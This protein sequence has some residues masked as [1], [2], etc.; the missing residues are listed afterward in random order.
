MSLERVPAPAPTAILALVVF[1]PFPL[2]QCIE[3][4]RSYQLVW[5]FP[6]L[7]PGCRRLRGAGAATGGWS[8]PLYR[9]WYLTGAVWTAGWLGLGTAF[10]LGRTR[11]GYTFAVCFL[12]VSLFNLL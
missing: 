5:A 1:L 7:S 6:M 4:R 3:R 10:L 2:D 8:E 11:F 9:T 12:L